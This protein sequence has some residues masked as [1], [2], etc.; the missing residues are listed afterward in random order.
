[1]N[2]NIIDMFLRRYVQEMTPGTFCFTTHFMEEMLEE[3]DASVIYEHEKVQN[4]SCGIE[5]GLFELDHLFVPINIANSHWIFLRVDFGRKA[6]ELYDSFGTANPHHRRY[7]W[8]MQR[9]LFDEEYRDVAHDQ[10]PDFEQWKTSWAIR[11]MSSSSPRQINGDDCGVF[12]ILSIYLLSRGVQ[13][14]RSSYS[15]ACVVTR[16]LRRSIAFALLQ[17]NEQAPSSSVW[18]LLGAPPGAPPPEG[19]ARK[20]RARIAAARE[21]KKRRRKC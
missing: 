21:N 14:S 20:R 18:N 9:Y 11:D 19:I 8:A 6:I 16:Q 10:R 12:T 1:M 7:L 17:A 13:L 5:E 15:Q 2:D 4:W 3:E